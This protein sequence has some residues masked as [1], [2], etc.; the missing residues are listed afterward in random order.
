[1]IGF[2]DLHVADGTLVKVADVQV[3]EIHYPLHQVFGAEH[4]D[5]VVDLVIVL[6]AEL[7]GDHVRRE[8]AG[9]RLL[10]DEHGGLGLIYRGGVAQV[11]PGETD[12][13][14]DGQYEPVPATQQPVDERLEVQLDSRSKLPGSGVAGRE[15]VRS[16]VFRN[17]L[18]SARNSLTQ[19]G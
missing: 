11:Q 1:M 7:L 10:L 2:I 3:Q 6:K 4:V 12:G 13:H 9:A 18:H 19:P 5:L 8:A 17:V 15:V 14:Q 16:E